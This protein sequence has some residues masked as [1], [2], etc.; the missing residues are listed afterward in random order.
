MHT[1][2]TIRPARAGDIDRMTELIL[3]LF[4][5]EED[6]TGD[7]A[8][9]CRGLEMFLANPAGRCLIVAEHQHQVVGMCSA[10]LLVST[11]E[12]GW[13]ALVEDVVVA[14][15]LRGKGI[16]RKMLDALTDWAVGQGARRM[17]LLA[18][19]NN[20]GGLNFYERLQWHRTNLIA[21]QK[22]T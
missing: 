22:R 17:D 1:E 4:S 9:Q 6:F 18:D 7:A 12:G 5:V 8:K 21:F 20:T 19:R 14:E 2:V 10:Q 3:S 11:A 16:G 15:T 13:K